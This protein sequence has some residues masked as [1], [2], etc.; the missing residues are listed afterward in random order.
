MRLSVLLA[1]IC[2]STVGPSM[3]E[4]VHGSL[5]TFLDIPAGSLGAA[6]SRLAKQRRFQIVYIT[7]DLKGSRTE[8]AKGEF[9]PEEA[10]KQLL[11]GTGFT[12]RYVDDKTVTVVPAPFSV[13]DLSPS[14]DITFPTFA[15]SSDGPQSQDGDQ[16]SSGGFRLTQVDQGASSSSFSLQNSDLPDV[17]VLQEILVSAPEPRYVAP[18]LRDQIGRIWAPVMIDGKG[19]F[20]LALD[21]A[22]SRSGV[23]ARVAATL[24]IPLDQSSHLM[25][26]GVTGS[27]AVPSIRVGSLVVGDLTLA[28][29]T[30]PIVTDALGGADGVLGTEALGDKRIYIDFQHDFIGITF[31][32]G[33]RAGEDFKIIPMERSSLGLIVVKLSVGDVA[34]TGIIDTGSQVTI[35]NSAMLK[36][37]RGYRRDHGL[38]E[39]IEGATT[40]VQTGQAFDVPT[41]LLGTLGIRGARAIYGDMHIFETWKMT[42]EPVLLIGM[43]TIGQLDTVVIDYRLRELQ[44]RMRASDRRTAFPVR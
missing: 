26:R 35:G 22:A 14:S 32:R 2:M 7:E 40:A 15:L 1:A 8:G 23:T 11:M 30:L 42:K 25:L 31:S 28:S 17:S 24:G 43:D 27:A 10:L 16:G 41:I 44:L 6:L 37:L 18:T 12:F 13:E 36:A 39:Q 34:A 9:T 20:R 3:A 5:K 4:D 33:Q 19:P 29:V 38:S 21:T